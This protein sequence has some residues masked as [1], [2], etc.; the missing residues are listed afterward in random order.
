MCRDLPLPR[1]GLA[2]LVCSEA[3][4]RG[5]KGQSLTEHWRMPELRESGSVFVSQGC[6][7]WKA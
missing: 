3:W 4:D 2:L 1:A 5:L 7:H 6:G